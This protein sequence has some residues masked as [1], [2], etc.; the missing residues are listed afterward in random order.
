MNAMEF[1]NVVL[2]DKLQR[3]RGIPK[4]DYKL[5]SPM[6]T[7]IEKL[8][9]LHPMWRFEVTEATN[10]NSGKPDA[11]IVKVS[12]YGGCTWEHWAAV[13]WEQLPIVCNQ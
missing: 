13:A 11:L 2:S 4:A 10:F 1:I 7:V 6:N 8:A 5:W 3:E 9:P 12:E